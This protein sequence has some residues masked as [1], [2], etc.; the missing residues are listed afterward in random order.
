MEVVILKRLAVGITLFQFLRLICV[1]VKKI[2]FAAGQTLHFD[3][4][5]AI[6]DLRWVKLR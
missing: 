1:A 3:A 5:A 2:E 4:A 6:G